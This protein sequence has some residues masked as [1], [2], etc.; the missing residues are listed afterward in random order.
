MNKLTDSEI[1]EL[2][3][4]L[5]ALVENNLPKDRL[6]RLENWISDNEEVRKIYI[7]FID[8][9]SSLHH[10]AEELIGDDTEQAIEENGSI[11]LKFTN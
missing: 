8:M 5:D 3:D 1:L 6:L 11:F 9:S 10:Y 2:H 4:L 7:E